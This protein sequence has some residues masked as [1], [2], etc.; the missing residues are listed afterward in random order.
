MKARNEV[1]LL[2]ALCIA[3]YDLYMDN[4]LIFQDYVNSKVLSDCII[5]AIERNKSIKTLAGGSIPDYLVTRDFSDE[6]CET[7]IEKWESYLQ[8]NPNSVLVKVM[9]ELNW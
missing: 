4:H 8:T 2:K 7:L 3:Q 9:E 5:S 6:Y 1:Y